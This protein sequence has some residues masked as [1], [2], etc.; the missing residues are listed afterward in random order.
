MALND[1]SSGVDETKV[2]VPGVVS[3]PQE[4]VLHVQPEPLRHDAFGLLNDD[5]A[6]ERQGEL[7]VHDLNF[8]GR[9]VMELSLIHI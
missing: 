2:V 7:L 6:V 1:V 3:K 5:A 9:A 8:T 4:G